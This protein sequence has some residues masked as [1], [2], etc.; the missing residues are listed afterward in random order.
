[1]SW[2]SRFASWCQSLFEDASAKS[3]STKLCTLEGELPMSFQEAKISRMV[4][5]PYGIHTSGLVLGK[6]C[7]SLHAL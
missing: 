7:C 3:A 5:V 1:M 2:G 4:W 6:S